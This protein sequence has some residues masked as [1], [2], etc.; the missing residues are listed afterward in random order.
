MSESKRTIE[1]IKEAADA[2]AAQELARCHPSVRGTPVRAPG[3]PR[4]YPSNDVRVRRILSQREF[5][6]RRKEEWHR[7]RG[8]PVPPPREC[9]RRALDV[10]EFKTPEEREEYARKQQ[11][12]NYLSSRYAQT[13]DKDASVLSSAWYAEF[14]R[15]CERHIATGAL[16]TS[17]PRSRRSVDRN[18]MPPP[19]PTP[20]T[21]GKRKR[22]R[23]MTPS[24]GSQPMRMCEISPV[25]RTLNASRE[26]RRE[27]ASFSMV[28]PDAA[29]GPCQ[30]LVQSEPRM[31]AP[32]SDDSVLE[33]IRKL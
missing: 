9:V 10:P 5:R 15:Q 25:Q 29:V 27:F 8:E 28:T 13:N 24:P 4:K 16:R 22:V 20:P 18:L 14:G 19:P 23:L 6:R 33:L 11:L 1:A 21:S 30:N 7:L 32:S 17:T 26:L 12:D 3:K 2:F 31:C